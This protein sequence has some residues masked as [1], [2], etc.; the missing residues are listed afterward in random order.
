MNAEITPKNAKKFKCEKC[1]FIS[2]KLSDWN[3]HITTQKH[4]HTTDT[5]KYNISYA[6]VEKEYGCGCGKKYNHRSSLFNHKKKCKEPYLEL[7]LDMKNIIIQDEHT[8]DSSIS[9]A[10]ISDANINDPI[11]SDASSNIIK[12]LIK[13]NTDFK[14]IIMEVIKSNSELQKQNQEFQKQMVDVCQKIQP[15]TINSNNTVTNKTFNL[16]L[17]LNEECKDA[18]NMSDFINSIELKISDLENIGK[19]GYVEGM[20]NIIIKHL[21]DTD[22]YKRPVHCSDGKRETVYVR[23]ENKWERDNS[24]TK[25]MIK[26]VRGV[27]KKNYQLLTSWKEMDPKC[28]DSKS[29]QCDKYMKIMSKVMDGDIEN[30]NKVIKKVAK[31]VVI[32]K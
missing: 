29:N 3:R 13:E 21:N 11:I 6:I 12:L 32:E 4:L 1:M 19:V 20:S 2:S 17:F 28:M 15:T 7:D 30:V 5:T 8:N 26:A 31:E 10:S 14:N 9:D 16:Q 18:M 24:E 27:D 22:M 23:E 25:Q